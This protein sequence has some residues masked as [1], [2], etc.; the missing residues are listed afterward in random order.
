M[1]KSIEEIWNQGF[2]VEYADTAPKINNLY[3]K[4]SKNLIE[5][6]STLAKW[7]IIFLYI[8]GV[9]LVIMSFALSLPIWLAI[10]LVTMFVA[11]AVYTQ[12]QLKNDFPKENYFNCYDYLKIVRDWISIRLN[13]NI[14]LARFYYPLSVLSAG[15]II[16]YSE[17]G[18]EFM[19]EILIKFP[20]IQLIM[21]TPA[22][23]LLPLLFFALLIGVFAGRVY[24]FD[25]GLIYGRALKRL[26][27][28][29]LDLEEL[30]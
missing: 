29:I 6:L 10:T 22:V 13:R 4:K 8:M 28:I 30:R 5:R 25:V 7:N 1:D 23:F 9:I 19:Q 15:A 26:D 27:E 18:E 12:R 16:R 14:R 17:G 3:N 24:R 2:V 21:G 11:P 20:D